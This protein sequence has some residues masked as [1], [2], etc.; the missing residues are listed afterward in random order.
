[1]K[2]T[3]P[4][5]IQEYYVFLIT[6]AQNSP[7]HGTETENHKIFVVSTKNGNQLVNGNP[8]GEMR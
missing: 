2:L 4:L 5:L 1:M 7:A 3:Q 8:R 6:F